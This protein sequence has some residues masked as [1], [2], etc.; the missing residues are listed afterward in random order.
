MFIREMQ[1]NL[2]ETS[3]IL[4][5]VSWCT[6]NVQLNGR[7]VSCLKQGFTQPQKSC[8]RAALGTENVSRMVGA[9]EIGTATSFSFLTPRHI[10]RLFAKLCISKLKAVSVSSWL[11]I[12]LSAMSNFMILTKRSAQWRKREREEEKGFVGSL[13]AIILA[14]G[15]NEFLGFINQNLL[16]EL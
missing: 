11:Q 6:H 14:C 8:L 10:Y 5:F 1:E 13:L 16:R 2:S 9:N 3:Q 4:Q 7:M 12:Q 15:W